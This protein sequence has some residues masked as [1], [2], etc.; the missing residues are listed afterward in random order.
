VTAAAVCFQASIAR[1]DQGWG[2]IKG[3][4]VFSG[5]EAPIA[6]SLNVNKDRE[7]CL[8]RGPIQS[9]ELVVNGQ[10]K[11][12]RWVFVWLAPEK[13]GPALPIN[14][15]LRPIKERTA[16]LDQPCCRFEPHALGIREGQIVE[17]R[18]SGKVAHSV[19]WIGHPLKNPGGNVIVPA[20]KSYLIENLKADDKLPVKVSCDIHGWMSAWIRVFD[21]PYFAVTDTEGRFEIASAPAGRYRLKSWSDMGYGP[22]MKDGIEVTIG[23]NVVVDVGRLDYPPK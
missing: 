2:A 3:R 13:G 21:Q 19:H 11:G 14:P 7:H 23:A 18:N 4:V 6:P 15:L 9:E 1:S 12:V 17:A 10:N 5:T 8:S 20:G 16:V 22:G